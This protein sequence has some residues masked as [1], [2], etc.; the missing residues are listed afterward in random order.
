[1]N[2]TQLAFRITTV[3][4]VL[5]FAGSGLGN[6]LHHEHIAVDMAQMGYPAFFMT[7]LG[8]WKVLGAMT[9]A[10]PGVPRLKEWA[11]AGMLFDLTGAAVSRGMSGFGAVHV[12]IP[13][14]LCAIVIASW[15]LRPASRRLASA[16]E[17][18]RGLHFTHTDDFGSR[19][20]AGAPRL[21]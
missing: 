12:I 14:A 19:Q 3:V 10:L 1:M 8:T 4:A 7:V 21:G 11:Y 6:L 5:V 15:A 20:N 13:L 16:N 9:I 18:P 17:G 2:H